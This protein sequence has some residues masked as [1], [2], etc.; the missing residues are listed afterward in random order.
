VVALAQQR[1]RITY[2]DAKEFERRSSAAP[3]ATLVNAFHY[4]D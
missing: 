1:C 4:R 3:A 2:C